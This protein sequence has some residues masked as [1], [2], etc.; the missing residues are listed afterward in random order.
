MLDAS[1]IIFSTFPNISLNNYNFRMSSRMRRIFLFGALWTFC[2]P[3]HFFNLPLLLLQHVRIV[4]G[5]ETF[6]QIWILTLVNESYFQLNYDKKKKKKNSTKPH[7]LIMTREIHTP[8]S[9]IE[10]SSI[11][12]S[13][14]QKTGNNGFLFVAPQK[15]LMN[16][17]F[18]TRHE[19]G[20]GMFL[21]VLAVSGIFN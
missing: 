5:S 16:V 2:A 4:T 8:I 11:A 18:C 14:Q 7:K 6:A 9:N 17:H 12:P 19:G 20:R 3:L 10:S 21:I 1:S 13:L 15:I